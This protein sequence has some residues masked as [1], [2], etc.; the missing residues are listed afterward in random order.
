MLNGLPLHLKPGHVPLP[1]EPCRTPPPPPPPH[2][3]G[4][5]ASMQHM[6][7]PQSL[8]L[9]LLARLSILAHQRPSLTC[10]PCQLCDIMPASSSARLPASP[11]D[12][13]GGSLPGPCV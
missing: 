6:N 7:M 11:Q 5:Q 12:W 2:P 10:P 8:R 13:H 4:W 9:W 3:A 1:I